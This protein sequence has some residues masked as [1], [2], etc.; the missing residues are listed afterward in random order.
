MGTMT[1][2]LGPNLEPAQKKLTLQ[3][4]YLKFDEGDNDFAQQYLPELYEQ[5]VERYGNRTIG[6]FLRM[7]GA[8][9]PMTSDQVIWSEQNRL[10]V[11][12]DEV[13]VTGANEI[14]VTIDPDNTTDN[15]KECAFKV[16]QTIVIYGKD[17]SGNEGAGESVK[18]I[19]T[20]VDPASGGT[21]GAAR[22]ATVD[23]EPY[24]FDDLTT[25]PAPFSSASGS[26]SEC[27][28]FVYGSEW[29]KGS[30]DSGLSSIQ[31]D[32]TQY[33]NSPIIL[34]DK[35]EIN[36]SDTAQIGWVEVATEDGTSGYLWFLKSESE[37]RL[38][39]EDYTEMAL[40]EGELA[41]AGSGVAQIPLGGDYT[42]NKGT[43]GLFA[44][45]ESRGHVYESFAAGA[46]GSGALADFD[47][48]LA[49]LDYEGAIEENM[50]FCNRTLALNIDNM[51]AQVNGSAQ[52]SSANGASYGLFDN[53]ASMA[54]NFGFD[55]FR[56]GSYDFYKTDWKYLNDASTRGL[57]KDIQG[58]LVPAGTS[59]VYD[60]ILGSNIRRPFLHV[61]Y[62][63]S[64]ADDRR[65]KSWVT[66]SVGGAYTNG[67]DAMDV[68]FLTE[69]CLV[70][71]A[72]NNFFL[73]KK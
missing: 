46:G 21:S 31:P 8:E 47:E 66:G 63:A 15:D 53:E 26:E 57:T 43:E 71:Q 9:M 33:Q 58:V 20:A 56:R 36:G 55:G 54:L 17:V 35:F 70:T 7:V 37:T 38:R 11:S 73:F 14:T 13:E 24:E 3:S 44:A 30:D 5:E 42:G 45:I 19:I 34:R 2:A 68:H 41:K 50:I 48:I 4:N 72:A 1:P 18:C 52:G 6:G 29:Q 60:Q 40:V 10:H 27:V 16:N 67:V 23:V 61:R 12:Y 64:E 69:R 39:F 65:M 28:A 49:Q 25:S 62:R 32:F 59:T 51:I 22:T